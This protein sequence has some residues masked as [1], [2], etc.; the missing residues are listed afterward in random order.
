MAPTFRFRAEAAL[1]LRRRHEDAARRAHGD[2]A[3]ALHG[4]HRALSDAEE[5]WRSAAAEAAA[6]HDPAR[7]AWYRNWMGRRR[8][9]SARL[10]GVVAERRAA[11][12][13][14]L[15]RLNAAHRDVRV[16]ERLRE[17][18]L[19]AWNLAARRAEQKELDWLGIVRRGPVD[20]DERPQDAAGSN[21]G[22]QRR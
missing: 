14:A 7:L 15:A 12:E 5:A 10:A 4:A 2:A 20:R 16:L 19:A 9:E 17:R 3:A 11:V 6:V 8:Q 13:K 18:G 1:G 21:N 22:E